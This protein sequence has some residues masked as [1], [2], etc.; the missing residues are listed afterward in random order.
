MIPNINN[1]GKRRSIVT[2]PLLDVGINQAHV[3]GIE[4]NEILLLIS[5]PISTQGHVVIR[6]I[7]D[8]HGITKLQ[9]N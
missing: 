6:Q 1:R 9:T 2:I 5:N 4:E 3:N 8:I 7:Q